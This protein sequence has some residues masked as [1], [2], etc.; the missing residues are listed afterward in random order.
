MNIPHI[1]ETLMQILL[2]K[3][4][5]IYSIKTKK[6]FGNKILEILIDVETM[7]INDLEAIHMALVN[8]MD[9]EALDDDY[10][11][12]LSTLGIERPL[13]TLEEVKNAINRYLYLESPTYQGFGTLIDL[14]ESI[15]MIKVN[16]KGRIKT[17]EI[18]FETI[19]TLRTAVKL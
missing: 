15:L 1:R 11:L 7:N 14:K 16:L 10:Y 18:P 13:A 9:P 6:E 4:L 2:K 5:S 19:K 8:T 17:L 3:D 12:E